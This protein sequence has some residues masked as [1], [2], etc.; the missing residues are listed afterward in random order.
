MAKK[1]MVKEAEN[2]TLKE[3]ISSFVSR[4]L[5]QVI[6]V[7]VI[8]IGS[9]ASYYLMEK[10][11]ALITARTNGMVTG[12]EEWFEIQEGYVRT[13]STAIEE[14]GL[15]DTKTPTAEAFLAKC[16][17]ENPAV[18]DFY[19]GYEDGT[20]A[21]GSEWDVTPEE[22]DPRTRDWYKSA[23]Q[24]DGV[25]LSEAYVDAK[26]GKMVITFSRAIRADGKVTGVFAADFYLDELVA[27]ADSLGSSSSF[28]ILID[29]AGTVLTHKNAAFLPYADPDGTEHYTSYKEAGLVDKVFQPAE[30]AKYVTPSRVYRA[31]FIPQYG[32]TVAYGT[33]FTSYYGAS[34][35]FYG[36]CIVLSILA[37]LLSKKNCAAM[38]ERLFKP[39][40]ELHA[41]ADNMTNGVI[42]YTAEYTN[43]DE[44]GE[45][46]L[47]IQDSNAAIQSYISD[48]SEKLESMSDGDLT[49]NIEREY[50]GDFKPLKESINDIAKSMREA[51]TIIA[52]AA[53]AVH[54]SAENVASGAGGLADD[55][56]HVTE[57]VN[58]VNDEITSIQ[59]QF[60]DNLYVADESMKLSDDAMKYL[61]ESNSQTEELL[62]AM[63]EITDKSNQIADII[64]IING[65]ASQ[66]NLLALNASIEAARAGEAG[67][68]FAVVADS[69]RDL[70]EQ[71]TAAVANIADLIGKSTEA[72]QK[73]NELAVATSDKMKQVVDITE[74]VH[75]HIGMI[76]DSVKDETEL[77]KA[78]SEKVEQMDAFATNTSATSEECV[79][80]SSELY[81]QVEV[82]HKEISSF[83]L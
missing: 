21:F 61:G 63:N 30:R 3:R 33:K 11:S 68:G 56:L 50:I 10:A 24:T 41:V 82:M 67:K 57:L 51:M 81:D 48:V 26:S 7:F 18:Y 22:Y 37:Y 62:A 80:L 65:I 31:S 23:L 13:I 64:E 59:A 40:D 29:R 49:V 47:A 39:F 55:V 20:S 36:C 70:A 72:V 74:D 12:A 25:S 38:I 2:M 53:D 1:N 8:I 5:L 15:T 54:D 78:V 42:N 16:I 19:V 9:I 77:V 46:C 6:L 79:A 27:L 4:M 43:K 60:V 71:T 73:G 52:D 58:A 14:L 28:A 32:I 66:T 69:V 45:L 75:N 35:L 17:E 76:V 34:L 83:K 44:I